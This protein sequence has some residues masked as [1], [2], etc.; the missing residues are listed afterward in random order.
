M[1]KRMSIESEPKEKEVL[2]YGDIELNTMKKS[3]TCKESSLKLTTTEFNLMQFL[4]ENEERAV[5]RDELL[6]V[7]WGYESDVETR[8]TDD[9]IK[10]IRKKLKDLNSTVSV[11]TVWGFGFKLEKE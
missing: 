3:A 8:V 5:S 6:N 1:F 9:T 7:I 2:T 11:E 4:I 10:R